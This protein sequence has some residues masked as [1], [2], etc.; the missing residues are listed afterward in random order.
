M[1]ERSAK[2]ANRRSQGRVQAFLLVAFCLAAT[3]VFSGEMLYGKGAGGTIQGTVTDGTGAVIPGATILATNMETKLQ[4]TAESNSAGLYVLPNLPP[5]TYRVYVSMQGFQTSARENVALVVGQELVLN[6]T[7][8]VGE[9]TQTVTV[10]GEASLVNTSTAQ[11]AGLVGEHQVRD[12]PLNGRSFDNLITLNP[13][14]V[15]TTATKQAASSSSSL[16]NY[17]SVSG[18]RPGENL[19]LWNGLEF[20]GGSNMGSSAPGGVSGQMLGIDAVREFNVVPIIDSA[21]HGHRAGGQVNVITHSGTNALH[22]SIFEF[23]RNS[24]LDAKDFFDQPGAPIP[25]FK[26]NQFGGSAGGPV[27]K[28]KTLLFVNHE[29]VL[30][31]VGVS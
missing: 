21:D 19:F 16:G 5:G 20:P 1:M 23:L 27:L 25:P 3:G 11:V 26:R 30:A 7:L 13:G 6:T 2:Y 24:S 28:E 29:G 8:Q 17:F 14:T 31:R 4:R 15:N 22:G 10:T 9:I 18:R 12:L